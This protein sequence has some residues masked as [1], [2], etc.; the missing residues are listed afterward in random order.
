MS[1]EGC[2]AGVIRIDIQCR[3]GGGQFLKFVTRGEKQAP[4]GNERDEKQQERGV[5]RTRCYP[6][7]NI[8]LL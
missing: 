2:W 6:F 4:L 7:L 1:T 5:E 8:L 3:G